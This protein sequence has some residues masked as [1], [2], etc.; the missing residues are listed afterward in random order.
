MSASR[1]PGDPTL[2]FASE[3]RFMMLPWPELT[4]ARRPARQKAFGSESLLGAILPYW[5]A[6]AFDEARFRGRNGNSPAPK[7]SPQRYPPHAVQN[8]LPDSRV[9]T[10]HR[11][12]VDRLPSPH[13][14]GYLR[15]VPAPC[16]RTPRSERDLPDRAAG[17]GNSP[18]DLRACR[19]GFRL[20]P[21]PAFIHRAGILWAA[22]LGA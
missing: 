2:F 8:H 17:C 7:D 4:Q 11:P 9:W 3:P 6:P 20:S 16:A 10:S 21:A 19:A 13:L 12:A 15:T 18:L 14:R 1:N 5:L 22:K